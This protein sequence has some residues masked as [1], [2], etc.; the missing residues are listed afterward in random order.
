[1]DL[2]D[3]LAELENSAAPTDTVS[4]DFPL[5]EASAQASPMIG[6]TEAG[7]M[8]AEKIFEPS[9]TR[10]VDRQILLQVCD[11]A[12][13][14]VAAVKGM[15]ASPPVTIP[16]ETFL[17]G[18]A[19]TLLTAAA[20]FGEGRLDDSSKKS[21]TLKRAQECLQPALDSADAALQSEAKALAREISAE[22]RR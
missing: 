9:V 12:N 16:K 13:G 22:S 20:V 3:A 21:A 1:L 15:F 11:V 10:I 7:A 14:E 17:V 2:I 8:P 4:L 5:P 6:Q 18:V 19:K